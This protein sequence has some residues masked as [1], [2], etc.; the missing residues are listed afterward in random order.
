MVLQGLVLYVH[1][2]FHGNICL[3]LARDV[4]ERQALHLSDDIGAKLDDNVIKDQLIGLLV[5]RTIIQLEP[6]LLR[7]VPTRDGIDDVLEHQWIENST[8][9]LHDQKNKNTLL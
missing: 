8:H 4:R 9:G 6:T 7:I 3:C 5:A 1:V 2:N